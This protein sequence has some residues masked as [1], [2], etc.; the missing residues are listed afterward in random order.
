MEVRFLE[1]NIQSAFGMDDLQ[2]PKR[3]AAMIRRLDPDL[4]ALVEVGANTDRIRCDI[5]AVLREELG[6]NL[7]YGEAFRPGGKGTYGVAALSK[8]PLEFVEKFSL[9]RPA[10]PEIEPR[11]S[12]VVKVSSPTPFYLAV[13]H[14]SYQGEFPD[15]DRFR[16]GSVR[17]ITQRLKEKNYLPAILS[18]DLNA[19]P[20]S[21][22]IR[23]LHEEWLV[24]NDLDPRTPPTACSRAKGFCQ[25]DYIAAMPPE[26][27]RMKAFA[28]EADRTVSDHHPVTAQIELLPETG[29]TEA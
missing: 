9:P 24:A 28:V 16:A 14:F 10:D 29:A 27:F 7:V 4:C 23:L 15:D 19:V 11:I 26:R 21:P 5:P 3:T 13:T 17:L 22:A 18:G 8:F 25:I 12:L 6:W 20:D 2:D 1:Y